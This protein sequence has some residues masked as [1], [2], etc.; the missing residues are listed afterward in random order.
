MVSVVS[1]SCG[2]GK[3]KIMTKNK[4]LILDGFMLKMIAITAMFTDHLG[5][6]LYPE[7]IAFRVVGRL[8][9]P[10]MSFFIAE[11]FRRTRNREKYLIRL[12]VLAIISQYPFYILF[13]GGLNTIFGLFAGL[14]AIYLYEKFGKNIVGAAFVFAVFIA[15]AAFNINGNFI[16]GQFYVPL[17]VFVFHI[18]YDRPINCFFALIAANLAFMAPGLI[19]VLNKTRTLSPWTFL[20]AYSLA[21]FLPLTMYNGK[22]GVPAKY[23]FYVFYPAHLLF[24]YFLK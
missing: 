4:A 23:L 17:L 21:A 15:S 7:N 2:K 11:G 3:M 13:N 8:T 1:Y 5:A 22:R 16:D 14:L 20:Q 18:F 10:I 24:L 19:E 9:I 12:F 6:S